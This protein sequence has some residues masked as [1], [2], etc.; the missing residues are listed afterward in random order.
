MREA[1]LRLSAAIQGGQVSARQFSAHQLKAI[2]A[3]D[4][5]IPGLTWHHHQEFGRM[6]L[7]PSDLHQAVG[8]S[9]GFKLWY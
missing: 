9:G 8:H 6:L 5:K 2:Q 1:T 3:G 7:I 4:V